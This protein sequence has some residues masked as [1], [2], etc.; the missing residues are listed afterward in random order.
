MLRTEITVDRRL[1]SNKLPD[2]RY[3]SRCRQRNTALLNRSSV[4]VVQRVSEN[5]VSRKPKVFGGEA[6]KRLVDDFDFHAGLGWRKVEKRMRLRSVAGLRPL[7]TKEG[8]LKFFGRSLLAI[9][10]WR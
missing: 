2:R 3:Y 6:E 8:W 10:A 7:I 1:T 9:G 5:Q 4:V